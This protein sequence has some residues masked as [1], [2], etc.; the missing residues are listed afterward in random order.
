[1]QAFGNHLEIDLLSLECEAR[2]AG[3]NAQPAILRQHV[4]NLFGDSVREIFILG[5]CTE[6]DERQDGD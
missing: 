3:G 5:V 4:E 1:M 2:R 6:I